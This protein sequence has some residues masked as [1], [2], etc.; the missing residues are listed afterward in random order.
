MDVEK[1]Q[2]ANENVVEKE[3]CLTKLRNFAL[4]QFLPIGTI[5]SIILG[6]FVPQPAAYLNERIPMSKICVITIFFSTGLRLRLQ[7]TKSA[8]KSYK[9]IVVGLALGLFAAPVFGTSIL[10]QVHKFGPL[11][12]NASELNW[13]NVSANFSS[14]A[15]DLPILGPREFRFGL[16]IICM[17][18]CAPATTLIL[19]SELTI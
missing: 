7:E 17:S 18:P 9:E 19:V 16:Q 1:A 15:I 14:G 4:R 5:F 10:N 11:I 3:N 2:E 8:V 12:A 13:K 6:I